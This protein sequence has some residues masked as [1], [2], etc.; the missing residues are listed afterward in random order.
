MERF[1]ATSYD[2]F[3]HSHVQPQKQHSPHRISGLSKRVVNL[4]NS[5]MNLLAKMFFLKT[6]FQNGVPLK[7]EVIWYI[8]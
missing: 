7:F 6:P 8:Y 3:Q 2:T 5:E 1:G 4:M